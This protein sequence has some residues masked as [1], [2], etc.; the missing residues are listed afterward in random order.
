[1]VKIW[2]FTGIFVNLLDKTKRE[3]WE[4]LLLRSL[5]ETDQMQE[6]KAIQN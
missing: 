5:P 6:Y 2:N 4:K 1:M 3:K